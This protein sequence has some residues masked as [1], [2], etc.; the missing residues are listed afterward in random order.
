MLNTVHC[1][2]GAAATIIQVWGE[3]AKPYQH[4]LHLSVTLG[5]ALTPQLMKPFMGLPLLS[6]NA[7][8]TSTYRV[9][10]ASLGDPEQNI[11]KY[12]LWRNISDEVLT[13]S[14]ELQRISGTHILYGFVIIAVCLLALSIASFVIFL[15]QGC[16]FWKDANE[17]KATDEKETFIKGKPKIV[18]LFL[19][20]IQSIMYGGIE[21]VVGGLLLTFVVVFLGWSTDLG[22]NLTTLFWIS[23]TL[24][25]VIGIVL[26]NHVRSSRLFVV[27]L[28]VILVSVVALI[29]AIDS[30]WV[31]PWICFTAIGLGGGSL[32]R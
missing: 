19:F 3:E 9:Y 17:S 11:T 5:A 16:M 20:F 4:A 14:T 22:S 13:N 1:F 32:P 23:I 12:Y 27:Q 30:H 6:S 24:S 25:R 10:N 28:G 15:S 2:S 26:A 29:F 31:V 7:S 18:I 8:E 21:E